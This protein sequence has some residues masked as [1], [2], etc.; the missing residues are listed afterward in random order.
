MT[1]GVAGGALAGEMLLDEVEEE[2]KETTLK[3]GE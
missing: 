2:K 3:R 1:I